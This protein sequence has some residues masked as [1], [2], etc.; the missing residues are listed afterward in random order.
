[1]AEADAATVASWHYDAEYAFYDFDQDA[2]DLAELLDPEG[3]G[4]TYFAVDDDYGELVGF[5]QFVRSEGIVDI[6]LG[7]RP[8]LVGKGLGASFLDTG[9][10]FATERFGAERFTLDVAAFNRRAITV[11]ERAG[12]QETT[13][14]ARRTNGDLHAFVRMIR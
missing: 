13:R 5:F 10:R 3:W 11:Y 12:F 8:D 1:M 9:M 6:G 4:D 7:L 2:E 14:L